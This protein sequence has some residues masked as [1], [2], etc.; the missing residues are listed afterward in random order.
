MWYELTW[1]LGNGFSRVMWK[2]IFLLFIVTAIAVSAT[3]LDVYLF[4]EHVPKRGDRLDA[5]LL[6]IA[7]GLIAGSCWYQGKAPSPANNTRHE[8]LPSE[9]FRRLTF[10][11][12]GYGLALGAAA[13]SA[14]RF[15]CLSGMLAVWLS[16]AGCCV[17][18]MV[19]VVSARVTA[20][21]RGYT[22]GSFMRS[23]LRTALSVG[24]AGG[25]LAERLVHSAET[26]NATWWYVSLFA[27]WALVYRFNHRAVFRPLNTA[28]L[29]VAYGTVAVAIVAFVSCSESG[30]HLTIE[31]ALACSA[32]FALWLCIFGGAILTAYSIALVVTKLE[33][34]MNRLSPTNRSEVALAVLS[35]TM[36]T[37]FVGCIGLFVPLIVLG[38][39]VRT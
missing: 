10:G 13:M 18:S 26:S 20:P 27:V 12:A 28:V 24:W 3:C 5:T 14:F 33:H 17:A 8:R 38:F 4:V 37:M 32:L 11:A 19:A 1:I 2:V 35:H 29:N 30:E 25:I 23:F 9:D 39:F 6:A 22:T 7:A 36:N 34:I 31:E 16:M 21:P 15:S